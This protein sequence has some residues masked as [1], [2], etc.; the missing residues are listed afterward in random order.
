M[1]FFQRIHVRLIVAVGLVLAI[2]FVFF[3]LISSAYFERA[4]TEFAR[5]ELERDLR[6]GNI[7][8]D[9]SDPGEVHVDSTFRIEQKRAYLEIL[10]LDIEKTFVLMT[11]VA[12]FLC[13]VAIYYV[14][15]QITTPIIHLQAAV[16][17]FG[18]GELKNEIKIESDDEVGEL[19]KTF[20]IMVAEI[21]AAYRGL[22]KEQAKLMASI[23]G[24]S[25]GFILV[26]VQGKVIL[27]NQAVQQIFHTKMLTLQ[28]LTGRLGVAMSTTTDSQEIPF[29][30]KVLKLF[31]APVIL[32][33]VELIGSVIL[34]E[35]I[36]QQKRLEESKTSFVAITAHEL[37]T[38]ITIIKGNA[39]LLLGMSK[40]ALSDPE[41]KTMID[42]IKKSSVGLLSIVNEFLDLT[43]LEEQRL[44]IKGKNF[45]CVALVN[46]I[47]AEFQVRAQEKH[48]TISVMPPSQAMPEVFA[49]TGKTRE[50]I[51]N[52]LSNALQYT[53]QGGI[54]ISFEN[55]TN[56]VKIRVIDTGIGIDPKDQKSLFQK[57]Q[58]VKGRFLHSK[59]Y[60]S[61]MGLYISKL[62]MEAMGG[63]I[64]LE[65]SNPGQGSTFAINLPV[66][67]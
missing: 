13:S 44:N 38:P 17:A 67:P 8:I 34:I 50:V 14:S 63:T 19:A 12:I 27:V 64:E 61:G 18:K 5:D 62:L 58:T 52:I 1:N 45:D 9:E 11:L 33:K 10:L 3:T 60:G 65:Q 2:V 56:S 39:E 28:D 49:D 46:D 36:T 7:V 31:V 51:L 26:D 23:N 43:I 57:F 4:I 16:D 47:V 6:Q 41:V 15:R 48:L 53:E 32:N 37:R 30:D 40:E 25:I 24:M 20:K 55:K 29:E 35:D 21:R 66:K 54:T 59:E 22:E 42:T